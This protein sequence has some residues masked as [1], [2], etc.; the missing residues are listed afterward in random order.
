VAPASLLAD[1]RS[2]GEAES[3]ATWKEILYN[4]TIQRRAKYCTEGLEMIKDGLGVK[5]FREAR[6]LPQLHLHT[7]KG[8]LPAGY[9]CFWYRTRLDLYI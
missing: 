2:H 4:W 1:R 9:G 6:L 7:D 8:S 5:A 3:K